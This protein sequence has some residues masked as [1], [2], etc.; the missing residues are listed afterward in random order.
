MSKINRNHRPSIVAPI[1]ND[2]VQ[3]LCRRNRSKNSRQSFQSVTHKWRPQVAPVTHLGRR[4]G[5]VKSASLGELETT[6]KWQSRHWQVIVNWSITSLT[7]KW[8]WTG[9]GSQ[10]LSS[11][12]GRNSSSLTLRQQ[13]FPSLEWGNL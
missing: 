5:T 8:E 13:S 10:T 2:P 12:I 4:M 7:G 11:A 1:S 9:R 3:A 6:R